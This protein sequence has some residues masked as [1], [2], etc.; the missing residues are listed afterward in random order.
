M[1]SYG[2]AQ[3]STS[4]ILVEDVLHLAKEDVLWVLVEMKMQYEMCSCGQVQIG[5]FLDIA[6]PMILSP[7]A[8]DMVELEVALFNVNPTHPSYNITVTQ[9]REGT[10][11]IDVDPDA[12]PSLIPRMSLTMQGGRHF[13]VYDRN[14]YDLHSELLGCIQ[15]NGTRYILSGVSIAF[16]V[17]L[18]GLAVHGHVNYD[19]EDYNIN[20]PTEPHASMA[21]PAV[22]AGQGSNSS[23][24]STKETRNDS[25]FNCISILP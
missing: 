3:T 9:V 23:T 21:P 15:E 22:A 14:N 24:G 17:I 6:A 1:V 2:P 10:T 5:S 12:N 7:Y 16:D 11:S 18:C 19:M 4:G 25:M 8:L 20:F 13:T